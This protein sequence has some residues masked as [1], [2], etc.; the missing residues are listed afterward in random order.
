MLNSTQLLAQIETRLGSDIVI[1]DAQVLA[2]SMV[3][4]SEHQP[5]TVKAIIKPQNNEQVIELIKLLDSGKG[6]LAVYPFSSGKNWGYGS[7]NPVADNAIMLDL[8]GLNKIID[9][10]LNKGIALIEAGVTQAQLSE[11]I[12]TSGFKLNMTNSAKETSIVGNALER[13]IGT[14]RHRV[15]DILGFEVILGNSKS[16]RVGSLWPV[17]TGDQQAFYYPH[18]I[19]PNLMPLFFQSNFGIVTKAAVSLIPRAQQHSLISCSFSA[20]NLA[21]VYAL[22]RSLY[23]QNILNTYFKIYDNRAATTY[24]LPQTAGAD[25][26]LYGSIET[27]DEFA[28]ILKP[29]LLGKLQHSGLFVNYNIYDHAYFEGLPWSN[30]EKLIYETF[31]GNNNVSGFINDLFAVNTVDEVD[32]HGQMGWLFFVPV[33]PA[34]IDA[35]HQSLAILEKYRQQS[36]FTISTSI[37]CPRGTSM[38]LNVSIRFAREPAQIAAAHQMLN[39][40]QKEFK[41]HGFYNYRYGI[42]QQNGQDLFSDKDYWHQLKALKQ[43]FD[44]HHVIAPQRYITSNHQ[45]E[46]S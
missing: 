44:P 10:D 15:E 35:L 13:G 20:Q 14:S 16:I 32:Q 45:Q 38:D 41:E 36:D 27:S 43:L 42:D 7:K 28:A 21:G 6:I 2:Q 26:L 1:T 33:I 25:Y 24:R 19:G 37:K 8:S 29:Y 11:A 40:L 18:G 4:V 30:I 46:Q 22:I 34:D 17:T 12:A 5:R 23:D 31:K 3:S 9:I 39:E